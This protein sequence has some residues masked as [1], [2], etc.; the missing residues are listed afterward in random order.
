MILFTALRIPD[1][2]ADEAE[3]LAEEL[4][5]RTSGSYPPRENYH[6]TI[7]YFGEQDRRTLRRIHEIMNE[8]P[9]P[10]MTLCFDHL[11]RFPG[12]RGDQIVYAAADCPQLQAWRMSL[13]DAYRRERI[14][15]D[16]KE[17]R[18][19]ITLVRGKQ[20]HIAF[21]DMK[22]PAMKFTP[23]QPVLLESI[24]KNGRRIYRPAEPEGKE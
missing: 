16:E 2:A 22:V 8:H 20:G 13:S 17:F 18:A 7:H 10:G 1:E 24:Q 12:T 9:L 3:A 21:E 15:F 23:A 19:H 6:V 14:P 4:R 11:I 5:K